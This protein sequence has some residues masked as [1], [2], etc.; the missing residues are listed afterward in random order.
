MDADTVAAI[1]VHHQMILPALQAILR[2]TASA[3]RLIVEDED[4]RPG[5]QIVAAV[6]PQINS[7]GFAPDGIQL[8][9]RR[10]IGVQDGAFA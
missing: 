7:F 3:T 5:V 9:H 10:C 8:R 1:I 4:R 2:M 6:S